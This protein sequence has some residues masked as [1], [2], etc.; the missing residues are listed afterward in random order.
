MKSMFSQLV[1][2]VSFSAFFAGSNMVQA[3]PQF[4]RRPQWGAAEVRE[5]IINLLFNAVDAMPH[6]GMIDLRT[7]RV[8]NEIV[9]EIS[10]TGTGMP[11]EVRCRCLDPFFTTKGDKGTGLG[12]SAAF[13]IV[14]RHEGRIEIESE[15]NRGTTFRI[16]LPIRASREAL[17]VVD[18]RSAASIL[19]VLLVDDDR[20]A[21]DIVLNYLESDHHTVTVASSGNEGLNLFEAGAFDLIVTD[22]AMPGLTGLQLAKVARRIDPEVG[23]IVLTAFGT[24]SGSGTAAVDAILEKPITR[25]RLR[26]EIARIS[27]GSARRPATPIEVLENSAVA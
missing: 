10:D 11:E 8:D 17:E 25:L 5:V 21:R 2:V 13:G 23:I 26:A 7:A 18:A 1:L 4:R 6:G 20:N 12:L 24:I 9:I 15:V 22:Q 16:L 27:S 3:Q 19:R 14:K